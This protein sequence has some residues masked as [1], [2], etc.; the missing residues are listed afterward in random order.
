MWLLKRMENHRQ[1]MRYRQDR[2]L[3]E[4]IETLELEDKLNDKILQVQNE[5]NRIK[6]LSRS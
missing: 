1:A 2:K 3:E 4:E 5:R 6:N